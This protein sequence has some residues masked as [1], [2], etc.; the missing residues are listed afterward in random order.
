MVGKFLHPWLI[1]KEQIAGLGLAPITT[2]K[3]AVEILQRTAVGKLGKPAIA[4]IAFMEGPKV[5]AKDLFTERVLVEIKTGYVRRVVPPS[6][7]RSIDKTES[8]RSP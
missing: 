6:I 4:Q 1:E 5:C 2:D 8:R 7:D 3:Y